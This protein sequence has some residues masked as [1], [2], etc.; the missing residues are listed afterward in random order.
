VVLLDL[1]QWFNRNIKENETYY[2]H[3]CAGA[4]DLTADIKTILLGCDLAIPI[5]NGKLGLG[6]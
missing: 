6:T 5:V 3:T 4:D 1:N 2:R